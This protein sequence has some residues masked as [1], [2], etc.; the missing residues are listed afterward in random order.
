MA[1]RGLGLVEIILMGLIHVFLG[2]PGKK[3]PP[4][5]HLE[6]S[7]SCSRIETDCGEPLEESRSLTRVGRRPVTGRRA[8]EGLLP[9]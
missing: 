3:E 7:C 1:N 9:Q 6:A 5:V 8:L 2:T 4:L